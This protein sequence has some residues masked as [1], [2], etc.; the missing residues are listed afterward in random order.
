MNIARL[1]KQSPAASTRCRKSAPTFCWAPF[2]CAIAL[3]DGA[4]TSKN[5]YP[6]ELIHMRTEAEQ[7]LA[8]YVR[9]V[10][11]EDERAHWA[12]LQSELADYGLGVTSR[13]ATALADF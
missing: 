5:A 1:F 9:D 7:L 3:I 12:P 2:T 13:S 4:V 6:D 8:A 10:S 11:W